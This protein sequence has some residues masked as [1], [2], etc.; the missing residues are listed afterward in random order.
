MPEKDWL[1]SK[2][3]SS[4]AEEKAM[5]EDVKNPT[6]STNVYVN[7]EGQTSHGVN[8]IINHKNFVSISRRFRVT[9]FV[10]RFIKI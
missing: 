7:V 1:N 4:L 8:K 6:T 10:L 9:A 2:T 3:T 5:K